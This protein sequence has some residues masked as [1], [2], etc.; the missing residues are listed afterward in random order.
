MTDKGKGHTDETLIQSQINAV[1]EQTIRAAGQI[2]IDL[3]EIN[4]QTVSQTIDALVQVDPGLAWL[5]EMEQHGDIDWRLVKEKHDEWSYSHS[6]MGP[7]VAIVV[8]IVAAVVVG[9]AFSA[10]IGEG[11]VAGTA[12]AAAVPASVTTGTAAV[13]AGW[14]NVA[15]T[16]ALTSVTTNATINLVNT[17]GDLGETLKNT[18]SEDAFKGY[19]AAALAGGVGGYYSDT[20]N[21]E[22]LLAK[23][24]AGCATGEITG[25]GCADGAKTAAALGALAWG[26]DYTKTATDELK[27]LEC[28]A[29]D[30]CV[31]DE[32]GVLRTDGARTVDLTNNP[33]YAG[34]WLTNS[35]MAK[36][37]EPHIYD[38]IS[39]LRNFIVDVSKVH[40]WQNSW[41]Y[42]S[43]TGKYISQG[44]WGD[45]LFQLYSFAGMPV[46][47]AYTAAAY[48]G[49]NPWLLYTIPKK[50]GE[51]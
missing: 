25:S 19:A 16:A 44:V 30:S 14:G 23:T 33:T 38:N 40:D 47:G 4:A 35:G 22:S 15:L 17:Q 9:P 10:M 20:Y 27:L 36:E 1:G 3:P 29:T 8:A 37:G 31:Y 13:A 45:S 32:R 5:K 6:G 43:T 48:I 34:N 46:A 24:A 7:A 21:L 51:K 11:A 42:D 50:S 18:F 12:M 28:T 49:Q 39:W 2:H 26:Y 41:N